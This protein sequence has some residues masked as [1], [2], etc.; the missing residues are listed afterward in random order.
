MC[1]HID[2]RRNY[3]RHAGAECSGVMNGLVCASANVGVAISRPTTIRRSE[4]AVP[5]IRLIDPERH[6]DRRE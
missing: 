4:G 1:D 3:G 6:T 5:R 2:P